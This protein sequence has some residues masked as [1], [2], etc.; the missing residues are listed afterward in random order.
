MQQAFA[1][2]TSGPCPPSKIP[3]GAHF[4]PPPNS[5]PRVPC[6]QVSDMV[7]EA[8]PLFKNPNLAQMTELADDLVHL[9]YR[10]GSVV[11][12]ASLRCLAR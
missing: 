10:F 2:R 3:I 5:V 8:L 12:H 7:Y 1:L 11:V 4:L 9:A 6:C